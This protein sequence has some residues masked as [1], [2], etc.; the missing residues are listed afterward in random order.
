[1]GKNDKILEIDLI[2]Y[3]II[4]TKYE[5]DNTALILSNANIDNYVNYLSLKTSIPLMNHKELL[6]NKLK[7]NIKLDSIVEEVHAYAYSCHN[8]KNSHMIVCL[9]TID[10]Q[11]V[12]TFPRYVMNDNSDNSN[13]SNNDN[14]SD[15]TDDP[16]NSIRMEFARLSRNKLRLPIKAHSVFGDNN[17]ILLYVSIIDKKIKF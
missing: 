13:N 7:K 5:I 4:G 3:A 17:E 9:K 8:A 12:M 1:M 14:N 2:Y 16:V 10:N 6:E 11:L 15:C